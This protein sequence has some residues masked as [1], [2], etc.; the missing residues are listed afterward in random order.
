MGRR[1][2]GSQFPPPIQGISRSADLFR[3]SFP[4]RHFGLDHSVSR[5]S[6][7][8]HPC[9]LSCCLEIDPCR[10]TSN[11]P[12]SAIFANFGCPG[13]ATTFAVPA[14]VHAKSPNEKL[15]VAVIGS[16][17]SRRGRNSRPPARWKTSVAS[18]D[19]DERN[20]DAAA[21]KYPKAKTY[22][23]FP[24]NARRDGKIGSTP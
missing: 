6:S 3:Q 21:K 15:N 4:N 12:P 11:V 8:P 20:L 10:R 9:D 1:I 14:F 2:R 18:C 19:V 24:P 7:N 23:R 5:K 17:R 13:A 16:G 22:R